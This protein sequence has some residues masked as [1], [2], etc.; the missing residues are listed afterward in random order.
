MKAITAADLDALAASA[1][2][3]PR[4]RSHLTIHPDPADPVQRMLVALEPGTYV[5]PHRH[6]GG[7]WE[8]FVLIRGWLAVLLFG[9]D[10]TVSDRIE[11]AGDGAAA[12]EIPEAAW[13]TIT[14]LEPGTVA[15]EVKPGP[16]SP[17]DDKGFAAWAPAE[18]EAGAA[19][20]ARWLE[21]AGPGAR[22]PR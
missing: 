6:G 7:R 16:Y 17:L 21:T 5:R 4:R 22:A 8:L 9:E 19:A 1:R 18:G 11:L 2:D 10:G 3:L 12:V 20:L 14:V 15:L 13:H